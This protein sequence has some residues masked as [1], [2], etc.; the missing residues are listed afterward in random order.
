MKKKKYQHVEVETVWNNVQFAPERDN[1]W[2]RG[3]SK[4]DVSHS[5]IKFNNHIISLS[6]FVT[7]GMGGVYEG[8]PDDP[9]QEGW[10]VSIY[11]K[12]DVIASRGNSGNSIKD[13]IIAKNVQDAEEQALE[14][15]K[16]IKIEVA[17]CPKCLIG[18]KDKT[19]CP[20]CGSTLV[21]RMIPA[22]DLQHSPP[23]G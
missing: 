9:R 3:M 8:A 6:F 13:S 7:G 14:W 11:E 10:S 2:Y 16:T 17:C 12:H 4:G 22:L 19:E 21:K 1:V 5:H 23:R 20:V 18:L 15:Y